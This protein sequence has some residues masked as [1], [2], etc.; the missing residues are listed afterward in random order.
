[1]CSTPA[2][3][4]KGIVGRA[5]GL[6]AA[7]LMPVPGNPVPQICRARAGADQRLRHHALAHQQPVRRAHGAA[8]AGRASSKCGDPG[9]AR[10]TRCSS[11][12]IPAGWWPRRAMPRTR[13]GLLR[14]AL[15]GNDPGRVPGASRD[16]RRQ[17]ARRPGR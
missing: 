5:V 3:R 12:T 11:S 17:L 7:G 1:V 10:P 2:C 9:T 16:A 6:A 14:A 15:R 8:N 13:S 4:R